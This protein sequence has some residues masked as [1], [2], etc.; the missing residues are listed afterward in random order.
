MKT[1]PIIILLILVLH[2]QSR[3]IFY[4]KELQL[5]TSYYKCLQQQTGQDRIIVSLFSTRD[6]I[7]ANDT[8][9]AV[10]ALSAGLKI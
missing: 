7:Y 4:P 3:S 10:N 5:K 2:A 6:R 8:Q 9:N 1:I